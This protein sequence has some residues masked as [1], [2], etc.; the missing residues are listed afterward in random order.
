MQVKSARSSL[1]H[2]FYL[3]RGDLYGTILNTH[4]L[5]LKRGGSTYRMDLNPPS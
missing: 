3:L 2:S 5:F 1:A 4:N